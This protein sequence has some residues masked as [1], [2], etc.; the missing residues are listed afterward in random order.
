MHE[1]ISL[2]QLVLAMKP[3]KVFLA[4]SKILFFN[5]FY[6]APLSENI[7]FSKTLA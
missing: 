6:F 4:C 3:S 7:H 5:F 2:D 1:I